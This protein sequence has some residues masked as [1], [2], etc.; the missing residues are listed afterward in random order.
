MKQ[1]SNS[2]RLRLFWAQKV[3]PSLT[4]VNPFVSLTASIVSCVGCQSA[5][6][7]KTKCRHYDHE[8]RQHCPWGTQLRASLKGGHLLRS[9]RARLDS[10]KQNSARRCLNPVKWRGVAAPLRV[11]FS[12]ICGCQ[13][14]GFVSWWLP[15]PAERGGL[16]SP[17]ATCWADRR[18]QKHNHPERVKTL[19]TML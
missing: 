6:Y 8:Q 18:H 2:D 14:V 13:W 4:Q 7:F 15:P 16:S 3:S 5:G 12:C 9:E 10:A 11:C 17:A 19:P 1:H